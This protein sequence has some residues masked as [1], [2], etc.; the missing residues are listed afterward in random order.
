MHKGTLVCFCMKYDISVIRKWSSRKYCFFLESIFPQHDHWSPNTWLARDICCWCAPAPPFDCDYDKHPSIY[1]MIEWLCRLCLNFPLK[2]SFPWM[3][4]LRRLKLGSTSVA[5]AR[6]AL[7]HPKTCDICDMWH[8][9]Y[10]GWLFNCSS[11]FSVPKWKTICSQLGLPF[12]EILNLGPRWLSKFFF[13]LV[14]KMG[15]NS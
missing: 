7:S 5:C 15:R 13:I 6:S 11:R 2:S 8:V 12:Q 1:T 14:L 9:W 4:H 10:T 3:F